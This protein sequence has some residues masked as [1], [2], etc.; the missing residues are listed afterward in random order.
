MNLLHEFFGALTMAG[1]M[2]T[3]ALAALVLSGLLAIRARMTRCKK[4][5]GW[6]AD[7]AEAQ[8]CAEGKDLWEGRR[9][10]ERGKQHFLRAADNPLAKATRARERNSRFGAQV[11]FN[12]KTFKGAVQTLLCGLIAV[13]VACWFW[14][15]SMGNPLHELALIQRGHVVAGS[16]VDTWEDAESPGERSGTR[17]YHGVAYRYRLP[18]GREFTQHTKSRSGR[19][20]AEFQNLKQPYPIQVEYLP[21]NPTVSRIKGDGCGSGMEWFCW[22]IVLGGLLLAVFVSPGATLL[23]VP[24]IGGQKIG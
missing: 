24:R 18:D 13:L 9:E 22:K 10:F 14:Y 15:Y 6:H 7:K 16:I 1:L 17:W 20:E 5:K 11:E 4:C 3:L 19:L 23:R 8:A 2:G 21:D 12:D